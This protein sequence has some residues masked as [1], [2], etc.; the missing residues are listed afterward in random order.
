MVQPDVNNGIHNLLARESTGGIINSVHASFDETG[1]EGKLETISLSSSFTNSIWPT[2]N[3][4]VVDTDLGHPV[5]SIDKTTPAI[6]S[7]YKD[8][9]WLCVPTVVGLARR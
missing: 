4:V 1:S 7:A 2:P 3:G 9:F 5:Y 6:L 8:N